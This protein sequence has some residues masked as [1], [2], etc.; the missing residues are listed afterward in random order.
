VREMSRHRQSIKSCSRGSSPLGSDPC[1]SHP[2]VK[3]FGTLATDSCTGA[4]RSRRSFVAPVGRKAIAGGPSA[5]ICK[6]TLRE[7]GRGRSTEEIDEDAD[8]ARRVDGGKV[9]G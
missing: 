1:A 2:E 8:N 5:A 9:Q 7:V 6:A 3:E 4:G